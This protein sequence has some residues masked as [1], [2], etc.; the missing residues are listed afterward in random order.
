MEEL[1]I[2]ET[3]TEGVYFKMPMP[4][5]TLII[6]IRGNNEGVGPDMMQDALEQIALAAKEDFVDQEIGSD[7]SIVSTSISQD[8]S[9]DDRSF[10][11]T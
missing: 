7:M 4:T 11:T 5:M 8:I 9:V 3:L 6:R 10:L 1:A 2:I